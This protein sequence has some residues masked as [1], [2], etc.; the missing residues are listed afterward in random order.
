M[1]V[2]LLTS[3][4]LAPCLSAAVGFLLQR[5]DDL[6]PDTEVIG[7]LNG[8]QGLLQGRSR[9]FPRSVRKQ[10]S[11]L[12]AFGGSPIGNSRV[13]LSNTADCEKKGLIRPGE[14]PF[15]VAAKQLMADHVQVL[16]TIGG[17]DTSTTAAELAKFLQKNHYPLQVVGLP[18]TI[19]NDI[20]P[21]QLSLGATTAAEQGALFF[22]N[23]V[24]EHTT[25]PG[26]LIVHEVM[27]RHCGWLTY[28]TA[29]CYCERFKQRRFV[30]ELGFLQAAF[31]I[32]GIYVPE[33]PFDLE[34]EVARL[35]PIYERLGSL[36]LFVSEGVGLDSM[37]SLI[38]AD[39]KKL[40]RDAFGHIKM[41]DV[42]VGQWIGK[43]LQKR[44]GAKK[45][46][47]QKSGYFARS[48]RANAADLH[49]IQSYIDYAVECAF[50][51]QSGLI[52]QDTRYH[53]QLRCIEFEAVSGNRPLNVQDPG[54]KAFLTQ[55]HDP[56]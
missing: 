44:I 46:L 47:V 50:N 49:R 15:E 8:Y 17:D 53:N 18:K 42:N 28:E 27:G 4:G 29:R 45:L 11:R 24:H 38:E 23:I 26:M 39:G 40:E 36:N 34:V 48:A 12:L 13:K 19:D 33:I 2:A 7:Y 20:V 43:E 30:P 10:A 31:E 5:Y 37:V 6:D 25:T 3:G 1:K 14:N 56:Q 22:E 54:I 16:H 41:A 55:I 9:I 35:K 52:G 51:R 21:V 32:H